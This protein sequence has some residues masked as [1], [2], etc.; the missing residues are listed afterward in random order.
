MTT[1]REM[2]LLAARADENMVLRA[3]THLGSHRTRAAV[4][5][6]GP[7]WWTE[8]SQSPAW[9]GC[10][11][12]THPLWKPRGSATLA[13]FSSALCETQNVGPA[14]ERGC[15]MK[16]KSVFVCLFEFRRGNPDVVLTQC[17]YCKLS[18]VSLSS[19]FF[20]FFFSICGFPARVREAVH[21]ATMLKRSH[22]SI[23]WSS[24]WLTS[25]LAA[26]PSL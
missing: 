4:R 15:A 10:I 17:T 2:P 23:H 26:G 12:Q 6:Q 25:W 11:H 24:S 1:G 20:V 3:S 16:K 18:K 7:G 13:F 9:L 22:F 19:F 5:L 21:L 14:R 8:G